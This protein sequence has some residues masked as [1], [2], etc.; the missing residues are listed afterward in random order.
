M[1]QEV[2]SSVREERG[3]GVKETPIFIGGA[4]RSGTTL[5][6]A[7][8]DSH[9]RIAC[10]PELKIGAAILQQCQALKAMQALIA[11]DAQV[12]SS[13]EADALYQQ[14]FLGLLEPYRKASGKP[15][16]A[17]KTP[18][19]VLNFSGL[20]ALF[21]ESPLIHI[22]RD[23][24]DVVA[25]LMGQEWVSP[26][27]GKRMSITEDAVAACRYWTKAVRKGRE[28]GARIAKSGGHYIEIH[29]ERLV[30]SPEPALSALF[31]LIGEAW[32]PQVLDFHKMKRA[33]PNSEAI[34]QPI[35]D[36][37]IGR[38]ARDL[39]DR[40]LATVMGMA[41]PLLDELGYFEPLKSAASKPD[42]AARIGP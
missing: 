7:V 19:N 26:A 41:S 40:D 12:V 30:R 32:E 15:R 28:A 31:S 37:S 6:R 14:L 27:T 25:S 34:S 23:G 16:V 2:P 9:S 20:H 39:S 5:L 42:V 36:R 4:A 38:W 21:P 24:R 3:S 8:L 1:A 17:E 35:S 33:D 18:N 10:G 11:H 29:Y 22:I 13:E